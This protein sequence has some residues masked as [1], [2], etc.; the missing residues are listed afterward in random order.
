MVRNEKSRKRIEAKVAL[1]VLLLDRRACYL[2]VG[3]VGEMRVAK[4]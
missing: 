4:M 1:L 3:F 2:Y